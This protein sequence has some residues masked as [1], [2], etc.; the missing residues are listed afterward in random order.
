MATKYVDLNL[1]NDG[2]SG[3]DRDNP[4]LT[5]GQAEA[6]TTSGDTIYFLGGTFSAG[7]SFTFAGDRKYIGLSKVT[8]QASSQI[9][10][11]GDANV[12]LRNFVFEDT[13]GTDTSHFILLTLLNSVCEFE[14]C[15]FLGTELGNTHSSLIRS[16]SAVDTVKLVGCK[17][18]T[19]ES[20]YSGGSALFNRTIDSV[21]W[22]NLTLIG[23]SVS[24][25]GDGALYVTSNSIV[26]QTIRSSIFILKSTTSTS[27]FNA[28][29]GVETYS[30]N[31]ISVNSFPLSGFTNVAD[32]QLIDPDNLNF[33]LLPNSPAITSGGGND[34]P[35]LTGYTNVLWCHPSGTATGAPDGDNSGITDPAPTLDTDY[36]SLSGAFTY[37]LANSGC[38]I[39]LKD[40]AYSYNNFNWNGGDAGIDLIGENL[41]GATVTKSATGQFINIETPNNINYYRLKLVSTDSTSYTFRKNNSI[42]VLSMY[43]CLFDIVLSDTTG[44]YYVNG[45][46]TF[47]LYNC[48]G[49][50]KMTNASG[51]LTYGPVNFYETSLDIVAGSIGTNAGLA[52][53]A[54][55]FRNS[56]L[57]NSS[58]TTMT[59]SASTN[60]VGSHISGFSDR[61]DGDPLFIDP[62]NNNLNLLPNSPAIT[63]GGDDEIPADA[64]WVDLTGG[65]S[66]TG[67]ADC[68]DWVT[69]NVTILAVA[70]GTSSKTIAFVDGLTYD[71][72]T[73]TYGANFVLVSQTY[74]GATFNFSAVVPDTAASIT[75]KNAYVTMNANLGGTARNWTLS[76]TKCEIDCI[77]FEGQV[78]NG[79]T[80][81][82]TG[83]VINNTFTGRY[84]ARSCLGT[85][86]GCIIKHGGASA[87]QLAGEPNRVMANVII[88]TPD[89]SWDWSGA[90]FINGG[91]NYESGGLSKPSWVEA[92]DPLIIDA[93]NGN[94]NLLPN[95]PAITAGA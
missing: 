84:F 88:W 43:D 62:D 64:V 26:N 7:V 13:T 19:T 22:N 32:L 18:I 35:D 59:Y 27:A 83:C 49:T 34:L 51:K 40:G 48:Q 73:Q 37:A 79:N 46:N 5:I 70:S 75:F 12:L 23:C 21:T 58:G 38:A 15:E 72:S 2:N 57:H 76:F 86:N 39:L 1:G 71:V 44:I 28:A 31:F 74:K 4:Y 60:E 89:A 33:N 52:T 45:A 42:C 20:G 53:F 65:G 41:H 14:Q 67:P 16:T 61:D 10:I 95:S 94:F 9:A 77:A 29:T 92:T 24:F 55:N 6:N 63:S 68:Y 11:N 25:T 69:D 50:Y 93:P 8:I 54:N 66:G 85:D 30:N 47:N 81:N 56:I 17:I 90:A 91:N 87:G 80:I 82:N 78:P 3:A 36:Y